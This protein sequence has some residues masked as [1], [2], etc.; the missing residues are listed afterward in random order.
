M[1]QL[2]WLQKVNIKVSEEPVSWRICVLS[3][4]N[5]SGFTLFTFPAGSHVSCLRA[6]SCL[7]PTQRHKFP[8]S[9]RVMDDL[10]PAGWPCRQEHTHTHTHNQKHTLSLCTSTQSVHVA[11]IV[12]LYTVHTANTQHGINSRWGT[13]EA[14]TQLVSLLRW[15][16]GSQM[17]QRGERKRRKEGR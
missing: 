12:C 17:D 16:S 11:V 8:L 15:M 1:I 7:G 14:Q 5:N 9:D 4:I 3:S 10:P 2:S 13:L 6:T